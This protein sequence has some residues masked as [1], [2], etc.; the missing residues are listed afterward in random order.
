MLH[1]PHVTEAEPTFAQMALLNV[2]YHLVFAAVCLGA[3]WAKNT[4]S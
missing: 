4:R 1:K 2:L 3:E